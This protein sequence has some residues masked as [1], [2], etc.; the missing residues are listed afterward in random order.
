VIEGIENRIILIDGK[1]LVQLMVQFNVGVEINQVFE[2]KKI[3]NDYFE[4]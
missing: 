3:D 2:L 1:Q 4:E